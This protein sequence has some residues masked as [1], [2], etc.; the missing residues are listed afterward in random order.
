MACTPRVLTIGAIDIEEHPTSRTNFYLWLNPSDSFSDVSVEESETLKQG[1][2]GVETGVATYGGRPVPVE[3][4]I[5]ASTHAQLVTMEQA[6][7]EALA[8]PA[9]PDFA[10][11]DGVILVYL[12]DEDGEEKQF[13]AR[14]FSRAPVFDMLIDPSQRRRRASFILRAEDPAIYSQELTTETGPESVASTNFTFQDGD[15]PTFQ[16]GDLPTIQDTTAN[17]LTVTND[18][19]IGSSPQFVISGPTTDPVIENLT[20]GKQMDFSRGSGVEL[21]AGETLTIDVFQRTVV[22]TDTGGTETNEIASLTLDSEWI[23]IEPDDNEITL[24]D[25]TPSELDG[26]LEVNFRD[27][28]I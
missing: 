20:T 13:Y 22:K 11:D 6:L 24:F 12:T 4:E 10:D 9:A 8:L 17:V 15:L 5:V 23:Y 26:Q 28:W 19:I 16:D 21:L 18:G 3:I 1:G 27:S 14:I 25:A 7:R 2:H